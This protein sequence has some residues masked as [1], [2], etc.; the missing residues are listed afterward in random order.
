MMQYCFHKGQIKPSTEA[1]LS[2]ASHC[3]QYGTSVFG[4][5]RGYFKNG[6]ATLFRMKDHHQR[7]INA[8]K[9]F[10][11]D[12]HISFDNF[13]KIIH[14]LVQKNNPDTDFYIRP[15]IYSDSEV[16]TPCF[17]KLEYDMGIYM[18]PLGDYLDTSKGLR[19]M[20]SSYQKFPDSSISTKAKASGA[21][22]H[23]SAARSEAN[24]RGYDEALVM[25][26]NWKIVEGSAENLIMVYGGEVIIPPL[27][28]DA[29]EGISIRSAI[30]ILKDKNIPIRYEYIDRSMAYTCDELLLTGTA[31]NI[32]YGESVDDRIISKEM[33]P[34]CKMLRQEFEQ[35]I[36]NNHPRSSDW[37]TQ[38]KI[39]K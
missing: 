28:S 33:G 15:F 19:L 4:G 12:Y 1:T 29:L 23:S 30:Q 5:M 31:A 20:I 7:L 27:A 36:N 37:I 38:I 9:I 8:A 39:N 24:N 3:I 22:L 21:Y 34:I 2:L 35:I 14:E 32:L 13:S 11:W 6:Q 10:G 17:H 25:D 26:V 18:I 16:L